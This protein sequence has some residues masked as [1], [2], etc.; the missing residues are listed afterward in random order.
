MSSCYQET[1]Q[2][3]KVKLIKSINKIISRAGK[4]LSPDDFDIL[5]ELTLDEM[6]AVRHDIE[7]EYEHY[8]KIDIL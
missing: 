1:D 6:L 5:W 3:K 8:R 4:Q 2:E 7:K